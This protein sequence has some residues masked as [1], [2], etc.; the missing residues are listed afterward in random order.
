MMLYNF[1]NHQSKKSVKA[2]PALADAGKCNEVVSLI[3][4]NEYLSLAWQLHVYNC[5][6]HLELKQIVNLLSV[7]PDPNTSWIS[8]G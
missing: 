2:V 3:A 5:A 6:C 8:Y 1:I 4:F 7:Y